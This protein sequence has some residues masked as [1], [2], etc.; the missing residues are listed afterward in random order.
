MPSDTGEVNTTMQNQGKA[1]PT[2]GFGEPLFSIN[3][4]GKTVIILGANNEAMALWRAEILRRRI[5]WPLPPAD[6]LDA[7]WLPEGPVCVPF[8]SGTFFRYIDAEE[9]STDSCPMCGCSR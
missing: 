9:D 1:P 3:H 5:E 8:W 2:E 6:E 4:K 7:S